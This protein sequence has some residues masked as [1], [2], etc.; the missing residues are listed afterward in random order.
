LTIEGSNGKVNIFEQ[1]QTP[2]IMFDGVSKTYQQGINAL[3]D[4]SF[5]VYKGEFVFVVG[6]SGSGKSTMIHLL[7]RE[8]TPTRGNVYF[9]GRNLKRLRHSQ[10]GKH[11]RDIGVVFQNFRLLND[12]KVYDNVA[13]A[14]RVIGCKED[15]IRIKVRRVLRM[16]G[17]EDMAD[18]YPLQLSGGQQ[19]R[20]AIARALI[21]N[22]TVL[23]A[24]EPTGNL[25]ISNSMEIMK[26]LEQ[27][28]DNGTTVIV[29]THNLELLETFKKRVITLQEGRMVSDVLT[30]KLSQSDFFEDNFGYSISGS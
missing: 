5:R 18:M 25:D 27:V 12:Q 20:V 29:V 30:D 7:T 28:N 22:P 17:L 14:Q 9:N 16:V 26:L 13:F 6:D 8:I 21:N 1:N 2:V 24:D 23:L 15:D 3:K 19:Q 10:V 4:V 11:R